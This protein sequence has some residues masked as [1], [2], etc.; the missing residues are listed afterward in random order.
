MDQIVQPHMKRIEQLKEKVRVM[1]HWDPISPSA[2]CKLP[3]AAAAAASHPQVNFVSSQMESLQKILESNGT[4]SNGTKQPAHNGRLRASL[5]SLCKYNYNRKDYANQTEPKSKQN[6]LKQN[7]PKRGGGH[8][9]PFLMK[10]NKVLAKT[11]MANKIIKP[12]E[13]IRKKP[14][15][16]T[17]IK[18]SEME[19]ALPAPFVNKTASSEHKTASSENFSA[20]SIQNANAISISAGIRPREAKPELRA[21]L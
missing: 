3:A 6:K 17:R 16:N 5:R 4:K 18:S 14:D 1:G 12:T 19:P 13:I 15:E 20:R 9:G 10:Q 2:T 8:N 11:T 7:N 21:L